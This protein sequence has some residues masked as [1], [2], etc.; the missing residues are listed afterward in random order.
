MEE[1]LDEV[2]V[3]GSTELKRVADAVI[4]G[5]GVGGDVGKAILDSMNSKSLAFH[6]FGT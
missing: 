1:G 3:V 5:N 2:A 6:I 4:G